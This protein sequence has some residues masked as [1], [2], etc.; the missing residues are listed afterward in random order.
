[1]TDT[2]ITQLWADISRRL[3]D[4]DKLIQSDR[5]SRRNR[6]A[7]R[8]ARPAIL[9]QAGQIAFGVI[10][11]LFVAGLWAALPT[12]PVVLL[13]GTL[14]HLYAIAT[15][16][17]AGRAIALIR[18][19]DFDRPL[20]ESQLSLARAEKA[21]VLS[22]M[23]AGQPWWFL[24]VAVGVVLIGKGGSPVSAKGTSMALMMLGFS[25][26]GMIATLAVRAWLIRRGIIHDPIGRQLTGARDRLHE[27]RHI[28]EETGR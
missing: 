10:I 17:M 11:I 23:V 21:L 20:L 9:G 1:M 19:I 14:V 26:L 8:S 6:A 16:A 12:D 18:A 27:I 5:N 24:W 7:A 15:I 2:D 28:A 13:C 4:H 22:R 25:A 3:D